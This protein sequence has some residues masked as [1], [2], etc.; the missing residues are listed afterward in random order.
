MGGVLLAIDAVSPR[1]QGAARL[2]ILE[3]HYPSLIGNLTQTFS[4]KSIQKGYF[5][6]EKGT[7]SVFGYKDLKNPDLARVIRFLW[8]WERGEKERIDG[9]EK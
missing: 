1:R 3:A 8:S 5:S 6:R 2:E 9:T 4:R 7:Q